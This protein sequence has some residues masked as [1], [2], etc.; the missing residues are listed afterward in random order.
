MKFE[1]VKNILLPRLLDI[2]GIIEK[3]STHPILTH[4][5]LQVE[6]GILSL[7]G[8]DTELTLTSEIPV[9]MESNGKITVPSSK[10]TQIIDKLPND[11]KIECSLKD[12]QF[13]IKSGKSHFHLQTLPAEDFPVAEEPKMI[14]EIQLSALALYNALTKVRFS[15]AENDVRHY[16]NGL[17][18]NIAENEKGI[19]TVT[20]DGHRLSVGFCPVHEIEETQASF[21]IPNKAVNAL[22]KQISLDGWIKE[23]QLEK[24]RCKELEKLNALNDTLEELKQYK[25]MSL[26]EAAKK[27]LRCISLNLAERELHLDNGYYR[28]TTRLIDGNYPDYKQLIPNIQKT[29][30]LIDRKTL[31]NALY[32]SRVVLSR[33]E[34]SGAMLNFNGHML[35]LT[36]RN[37]ENE[38]AEEQIEIVNTQGINENVGININYLID[39]ADNIEGNTLQIHLENGQSPLLITTEEDVEMQYVVMPMR[40]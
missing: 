34:D 2:N 25:K 12:E 27:Q 18:I 17:Y 7:L 15:M 14:G 3:N 38:I 24:D 35:H 20:T 37:S 23:L 11:A 19:E 26:Y 28:I 31:L 4:I 21:I 1:V 32:R 8:T 39:I 36:A 9:E 16:L 29:P 13:H 33:K 22:I 6:D 40:I 10:F 30:I 5:Y